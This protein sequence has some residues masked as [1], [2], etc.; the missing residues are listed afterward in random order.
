[1]PYT[2][3]L[4]KGSLIL[5]ISQETKSKSL[6]KGHWLITLGDR[7]ELGSIQKKVMRRM[8]RMRKMRKKMTHMKG[9]V[10]KKMKQMK[11]R[12][13]K[14]MQMKKRVMGKKKM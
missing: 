1:V 13:G 11:K 4:W 7:P 6:Q 2:W 3:M 14:K 10:R 9:K 12:V 5:Q 8:R